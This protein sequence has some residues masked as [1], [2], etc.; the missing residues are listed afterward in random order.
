MNYIG[1]YLVAAR[2]NDEIDSDEF[3]DIFRQAGVIGFSD[4][5]ILSIY[6]LLM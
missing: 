4:A 1:K 6:K 5:S 2:L 3:V